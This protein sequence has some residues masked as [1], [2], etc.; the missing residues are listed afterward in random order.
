MAHKFFIYFG[1]V[2]AVVNI[3]VITVSHITISTQYKTDLVS[4]R[5][6]DCLTMKR[7]FKQWWSTITLISTKQTI[8]SHLKKV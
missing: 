8:I 1:N 5:I 6:R 7:K 2:V 4:I 3:I